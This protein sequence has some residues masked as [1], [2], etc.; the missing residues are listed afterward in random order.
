MQESCIYNGLSGG[1]TVRYRRGRY[2]KTNKE[3]GEINNSKDFFLFLF[4]LTYDPF[5]MLESLQ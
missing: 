1:A 3:N 5:K 4:V 2:Q